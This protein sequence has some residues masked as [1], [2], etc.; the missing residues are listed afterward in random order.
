MQRISAGGLELLQERSRDCLFFVGFGRKLTENRSRS[1]TKVSR[2]A[3]RSG[4]ARPLSS[5]S[6]T[7]AI[8]QLRDHRYSSRKSTPTS[9]QKLPRTAGEMMERGARA[10]LPQTY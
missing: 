9:A 1:A 7:T 2:R 6:A 4:P 8:V 10:P 5:T 3:I